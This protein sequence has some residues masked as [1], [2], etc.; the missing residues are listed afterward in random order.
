MSDPTP[1]ATP[2]SNATTT[3]A[4]TETALQ[5]VPKDLNELT[6]DQL[7]GLADQRGVDLAGASRKGDIV[8]RLGAAV[9]E[10]AQEAPAQTSG[11]YQVRMPNDRFNGVRAGVG[12]V[13]GVGST[14]NRDVAAELQG[15]GYQV[16]PPVTVPKAE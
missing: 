15:L 14:D 5:E 2:D 7:R 13:R 1:T 8:A 11:R 16:D 12:F 3:E 4:S 6:V 9:A 10:A